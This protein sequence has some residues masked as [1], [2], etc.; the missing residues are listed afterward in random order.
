MDAQQS[1]DLVRAV[2]PRRLLPVHYEE[3]GV[4][5]SPLSDFLAEAD[6]RGFAADVVHYERGRGVPVGPGARVTLVPQ[7]AR[8]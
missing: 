6:R 8:P 5:R 3:Y 7:H 4:M 2:R 1:A